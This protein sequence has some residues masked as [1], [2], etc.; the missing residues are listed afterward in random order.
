[1]KKTFLMTVSLLLAIVATAQTN[2][3]KITY[4]E[5]LQAAKSEQ[6]QV[7]ID[8]YTSWCGPC[9][10]MSR[11]TFPTK[12]VGDYMN[13]KFV[14][15]QIDAEKGEGVDLAKRFKITAYPTFV[16]VN[17]DDTEAA[18]TSG[19]SPADEF[20]SILERLTNPEM[21][22]EKIK[23][24]YESGDRSAE[25]VKNYVGLLTEEVG[26][27]RMSEEAYS[28]KLDSINGLVMDY[29]NSLSDAQKVAPENEFIYRTYTEDSEEPS[30]QFYI[31]NRKK[32][33]D[34]QEVDSI[35]KSY[36]FGTTYKYLAY[37]KPYN[38]QKVKALEDGIKK[39]KVN[40]DN[41]FTPALKIIEKMGGDNKSLFSTISSEF[42][43]LDQSFQAG[44]I[45][46]LCS[47]FSTADDATKKAA[48][49][50]I[51]QQLPDMNLR[52]MYSV[53]FDLGQLEGQ[54]H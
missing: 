54:G 32:F 4:A 27:T 13:K 45:S 9:K 41:T 29:F 40:A 7:F 19:Y 1:M 46:G 25:S 31:A 50:V 17:S 28:A 49:H 34:N 39:E 43:N 15:L 22:P 3:R 10:M 14:S 5:A 37:T 20:L 38:A 51:R 35:V 6:K 42:K 26:N 30:A 36:F 23:A 11:N 52:V 8:F 47:H 16:I 12:V 48:A 24:R 33:G 2:F 21:T 44:L 18:R 53:V